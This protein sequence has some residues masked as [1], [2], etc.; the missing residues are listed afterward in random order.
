MKRLWR[1]RLSTMML[2]VPT[3]G[4]VLWY[5][6][7]DWRTR[8]NVWQ[9]NRLIWNQLDRTIPLRYPKG[10][11]LDEFLARIRDVTKGEELATGLRIHID[12]EGLQD[13]GNDM[14]SIV[15]VDVQDRPLREAL[16]RALEP[17][18]LAYRVSDGI[19]V[20]SDK[21]AILP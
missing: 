3:F 4:L 16:K 7:P 9:G 1:W 11:R 15:R 10:I 17:M 12:P 21:K 14:R 18:G 5:N 19:L 8:Y 2:L 20:V 6:L 13:S